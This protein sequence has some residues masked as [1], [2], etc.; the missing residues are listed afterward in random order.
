[1]TTPSL[2]NVNNEEYTEESINS[3]REEPVHID[4]NDNPA[5]TKVYT[6]YYKESNRLPKQGFVKAN[7]IT[8]VSALVAITL[9][10]LLQIPLELAVT[11][12]L[13]LFIID[14]IYT[15]RNRRLIGYELNYLV[16]YSKALYNTL[17]PGFLLV[18]T[19]EI[20]LL[21]TISVIIA[22]LNNSNLV[23]SV[24][25]FSILFAVLHTSA[26]IRSYIF[27]KKRNKIMDS[28]DSDSDNDNN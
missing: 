5:N 28:K 20:I 19:I 1:M 4:T 13:T 25:I 7:L 21:L 22:W 26:F 2:Y 24:A 27:V 12:W 8:I 14:A 23:D 10:F 3:N 9:S 16:R 18:F 17:I 6:N 11:L 15:Y